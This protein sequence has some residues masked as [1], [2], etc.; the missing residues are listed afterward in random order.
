MSRF[1]PRNCPIQGTSFTVS[2][3]LPSHWQL[4]EYGQVMTR[5]KVARHELETMFLFSWQAARLAMTHSSRDRFQAQRV[6]CPT[7]NNGRS[8][9]LNTSSSSRVQNTK[10]VT[11]NFT[12][13]KRQLLSNFFVNAAKMNSSVH[14]SIHSNFL[15]QDFQRPARHASKEQETRKQRSTLSGPRRYMQRRV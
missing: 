12:S 13:W 5:S 7:C 3:N 10:T 4:H 9:K 2:A 11:L 14:E 8:L 6:S 15:L 1:K